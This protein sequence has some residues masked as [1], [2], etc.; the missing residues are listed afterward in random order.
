[1]AVASKL[2][3][4]AS[5]PSI[6]DACQPRADLLSG[7]FNPEIF[8]ASLRQVLS[9][10]TNGRISNPIYSDP[11]VFFTEATFPTA[12][13]REVVQGVFGRLSG[14][15]SFPVVQRLE[16]AFGGGKTHTLIAIAHLAKQGHALAE[17]ASDVIAGNLLPAK[18]DIEFIGIVGDAVEVHRQQGADLV[19]H[20][21]WGAIAERIGGEALYREFQPILES[22][23][24]PAADN[25]YFERLFGGRKV[26]LIIDELAQYCARSEAARSRGAEQVAA[27]FMS[28]LTYAE[29]HPHFAM[30]VT[31]ASD[32]NAFGSY[33]ESIR[34]VTN[35]NSHLS[36]D[37]AE[38]L[39]KRSAGQVLSVIHRSA[40][41]VTPVA[42]SEL[43][44]IMARRLFTHIDMTAARQVA[45]AY[46]TMYRQ[47]G[48]ELPSGVTQ[49]DF[50]DRM[51]ANYPF[52]PTFI[53]YLSQKLAQVEA[54]Q[55][56]RGVLRTLGRLVRSVWRSKFDVPL[57]QTCHLD[58]SD[59]G[60]RTELLSRT[61]NIDMVVVL[62][63]DISKAGTAEEAV[64]LTVAQQLDRDNPHP[65]GYPLTEWAW[66]TV[67]LNSLV[68]RAGGLND[69]R[70]GIALGQAL[71]ETA[72][73][74]LPP[75]QVKSALQAISREAFYLREQEGRFYANTS[76]TINIILRR[77]RDDVTMQEKLQ[78]I[79]DLTRNLLKGKKAVCFRVVNDV[80][81]SADIQDKTDQPSLAL[82]T[83][84]M[85]E[86]DPEA[87]VTR[88]GDAPRLHQNYVFVLSPST[89]HAKGEI[90][91][92]FRVK[93]ER[94]RK[95]RLL[96][97]ASWVVAA[98]KL[99]NQP[100]RW[101]VQPKAVKEHDFV[102]TT[103][104]R[105]NDLRT[106]VE[107]T[108]SQL[109][110]SDGSGKVGCRRI[111]SAGGESGDNLL[112]L[113]LKALSEDG[114]LITEAHASSKEAVLSLSQM[115]FSNA[116]LTRVSKLREQFAQ[117]R[118]WPVLET[119]QL[120]D[121]LLLTGVRTG[122]WC[123]ALMAD[124]ASDKPSEFY[125]SANE[126]PLGLDMTT[127]HW[128]IVTLQ[129]AAQRGWGE[130]KTR[131]PLKL[132]TWASQELPNLEA[133]D[134]ER[135]ANSVQEKHGD[136]DRGVLWDQMVQQVDQGRLVAFPKRYLDSDQT[137]QQHE[138]IQGTGNSQQVLTPDAYAVM[139][140]AEASRRGWLVVE[141][142]EKQF[143]LTG[144][145]TVKR[146][147]NALTS[148]RFRGSETQI[149]YLE[150]DLALKSG[151][152]HRFVLEQATADG[153]ARMNEVFQCLQG[154]IDYADEPYADIT[155]SEPAPE[156]QLV[157]IL[158]TL[159]KD[160][161]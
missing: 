142:T 10:Y 14:D 91:E 118:H 130:S 146:L 84:G 132:R 108:Y 54:F 110:Y 93:A 37:A 45:D 49:E 62:E 65:K 27:F 42:A 76:P 16:T 11:N 149:E 143:R 139:T 25:P 61:E 2:A 121:T 19:P 80:A 101:N 125:T 63:A 20:T 134:L 102:E 71:L 88:I 44:K 58:L 114:E 75:S 8:K 23:S 55:G 29:S 155:I 21:L 123:L 89:T 137:P 59:D 122:Q 159:E 18:G 43:S 30:V 72:Q 104:T 150:L 9:D 31:L 1:M 119:P 68:G 112:A 90:W 158:T 66:K 160:N 77:I 52:H 141:A 26:L 3:N 127:G 117:I 39:L 113:I 124:E 15:A 36:D 103:K 4:I 120:L 35:E 34:A 106:L 12:G 157:K 33:N 111:S 74:Q 22:P 53:E 6:L 70:F 95:Q 97:L 94:E 69:G 48:S 100:A 85:D 60:I 17:V 5:I 50:R 96:D 13:L 148:S 51:V 154:L 126:P 144:E 86:F 131:D 99:E 73:P 7:S 64:G 107:Q 156:C 153:L 128:L 115:F 82:L 151:G 136:F 57:L 67:F 79:H 109:Y 105:A 40:S 152:R 47:S 135:L 138:L 81:Q 83:F 129:G 116:D 24:A 161:G 147:I 92:E 56:T 32:H 28:L 38:A 78:T 98:N 145:N 140:K 46:L 41:G 87:F 133:A